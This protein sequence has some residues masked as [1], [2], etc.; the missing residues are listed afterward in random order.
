M[1]ETLN[2]VSNFIYAR[3]LFSLPFQKKIIVKCDPRGHKIKQIN[4]I[5]AISND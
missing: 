4:I 3:F 1:L 5:Q 2:F